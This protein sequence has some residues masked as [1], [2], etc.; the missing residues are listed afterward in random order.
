MIDNNESQHE[1]LNEL[2]K[3][4]RSIEIKLDEAQ[5]QVRDWRHIETA[6]TNEINNLKKQ[7]R[8]IANQLFSEPKNRQEQDWSPAG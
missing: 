3:S 2:M 8:E 4:I 7:A 6:H 5:R 1:K